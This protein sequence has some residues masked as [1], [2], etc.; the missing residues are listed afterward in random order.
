[1][2]G[3]GGMLWFFFLKKYVDA[4]LSRK[5][6]FCKQNARKKYSDADK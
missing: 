2:G 6:Y 4:E 3:G 5:D 1:L